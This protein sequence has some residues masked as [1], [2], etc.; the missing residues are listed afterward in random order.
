MSGDLDSPPEGEAC[1]RT[2]KETLMA[3]L[4]TVIAD[5]FSPAADMLPFPPVPDPK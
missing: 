3:E 4:L 5:W 2:R 1:P